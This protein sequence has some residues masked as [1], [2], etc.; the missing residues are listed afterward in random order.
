MALSKSLRNESFLIFRMTFGELTTKDRI[1]NHTYG[2]TMTAQQPS[3]LFKTLKAGSHAE[4]PKI[5]GGHVSVA[6]SV[7]KCTP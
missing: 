7:E 5:S 6:F 2:S 3:S 4:I 1:A